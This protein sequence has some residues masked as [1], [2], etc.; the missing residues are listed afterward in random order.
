MS[1]Y[2]ERTV[3]AILARDDLGVTPP[4]P[5]VMELV[6]KMVEATPKSSESDGF[7]IKTK[8]GPSVSQLSQE[9]KVPST[10][11][12]HEEIDAEVVPA[13]KTLVD[14]TEYFTDTSEVEDFMDSS[15]FGG[16]VFPLNKKTPTIVHVPVQSEETNSDNE[17]SEGSPGPSQEQTNPRTATTVSEWTCCAPEIV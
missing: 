6:E 14:P 11:G 5:G 17:Y 12:R 8:V 15:G 3:E 7:A 9:E 4:N 2:A 13:A 16:P 1:A 10:S